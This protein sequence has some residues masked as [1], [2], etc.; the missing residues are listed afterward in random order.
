MKRNIVLLL[1]AAI[2]CSG[3]FLACPTDDS[4]TMVNV[5]FDANGGVFASG[6]ETEV[7]SI[8]RGSSVANPPIPAREDHEFNGLWYTEPD[9]TGDEFNPTAGINKATTYYAKWVKD[10]SL[11]VII[12]FDANEGFFSRETTVDETGKPVY[13]DI[14]DKIEIEISN[15]STILKSAV[16]FA[17]NDNGEFICWNFKADGSGTVFYDASDSDP[18]VTGYSGDEIPFIADTTIY[19]VWLPNPDQTTPFMWGTF[20]D[21]QNNGGSSTV[22]LEILEEEIDGEM[23]T[24]YSYT[25]TR[26][27]KF[28]YGFIGGFMEPN[29]DVD[30][31]KYGVTY[32]EIVAQMKT[33]KAVSFKTSGDGKQY[34]FMVCTTDRNGPEV[35]GTGDS[36]HYRRRNG[37]NATANTIEIVQ[38]ISDLVTPRQNNEYWG[39]DTPFNQSLVEKYQWQTYGNPSGIPEKFAIKFWDFKLIME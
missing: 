10:S 16:P 8:E 5:T 27:N 32:D 18:E 22:E 30:V 37:F 19:A 7:V 21:R 2:A 20:D 15:N 28:T 39:M 17:F 11:P 4:P 6:L 34:H 36:S 23:V 1:I 13:S 29:K 14:I 3:L 35:G 24:V 38:N 12:T 25:G 9:G 33:A 31:E 26:T